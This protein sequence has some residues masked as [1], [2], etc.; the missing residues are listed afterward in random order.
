MFN[1]RH[2]LIPI[3]TKILIIFLFFPIIS[4][5]QSLDT[6]SLRTALPK[7]NGLSRLFILNELALNLREIAQQ[8]ALDYS[9]EAEK[10]AIKLGD[11]SEE[12]KAKENIG[13]IYYRRGKWQKTFDYSNEAYD[14]AIDA[15]DMRVAA[16]ILNSMGALYFE[17]ENFP[18]A[19]E[20]FKKAFS[21][22]RE[23]DD[24][25]T[26]IRSL[27][28]LSYC[29]L[30]SGSLDSAL[31]YANQSLG[32][33]FDSGMPYVTTFP[34]RIKGDIFLQRKLLDSAA[35]QFEES[36]RIA[37]ASNLT[38]FKASL[39]HRLGNVYLQQGKYQLA[40]QALTEGIKISEENKLQ[41]ELSKSHLYLARYFE[42]MGNYE[43]AY[44]E[45]VKF[46][47]LNDSLT[48]KSTHDRIALMQGMFQDNLNRSE[49]DL[50]IS[51]NENQATH[52]RFV[53]RI[54]IVIGI[55]TFLILGL[56]AWLFYLNRNIK[57]ANKNLLLQQ[58]QI[59]AQNQNL[60]YNSKE[61]EEINQTKNKLFSI[62]GHDLKGP[63][64][65]VKTISDL[66]VTDD[67]EEEEFKEL[68]K[69]LKKDV[70]SVYFT[71]NNTLRWSVTQME[72]FKLS[73]S[74]FNLAELISE[75]IVLAE[76][77]IKSKNIEIRNTIPLEKKVIADR[78]IL[79]VIT[80][81]ILSNA[82]KFS[83]PGSPIDLSVKEYEDIIEF[84]VTDYGAGMSDE[85]IKSILSENYVI[86]DSKPGTNKEKGSGL[87]LQ[88]CKE[89][90]R[91][92]GGDLVIES[93]LGV[94]TI[95]KVQIPI[96]QSI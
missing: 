36:L 17:Q 71:L 5:A 72:G 34:K 8:E 80:R 84:S 35:Y 64:G 25:Y 10:L 49:M 94:G 11:K 56:L 69:I 62:L 43:M 27:N 23:E 40:R 55:G 57:K 76:P 96:V 37:E 53:Q 73:P 79:D 48:N 93:T 24:V 31:F 9:F 39:L 4:F 2:I 68:I 42:K 89:F 59:S 87:G 90:A 13:W 29:F 52:L 60:A 67:L 38:N 65:Q 6:D 82:L 83:D 47:L 46:S 22:S 26:T 63:I 92:N 32:I 58:H 78:D 75:N 61:L 16:R 1:L 44:L 12:A 51:Q 95:I 21:I 7:N 14:L 88:I 20:Q 19:I 30:K 85:Q 50:L 18:L 33:N 81:N 45:Q 91:M 15:E 41:D 70:D 54:A 66:I 77:Q 86:T 3:K 28:N 74:T